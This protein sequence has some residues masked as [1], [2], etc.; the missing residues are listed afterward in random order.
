MVYDD[1]VDS[2]EVACA[3]M[4]RAPALHAVLPFVND[5]VAPELRTCLG[6]VRASVRVGAPVFLALIA[7]AGL[8]GAW[9][10]GIRDVVS[11]APVAAAACSALAAML[12]AAMAR[13]LGSRE[14]RG[15]G[16]Q[17]VVHGMVAVVAVATLIASLLGWIAAPSWVIVAGMTLAWFSGI[18][19]GIRELAASAIRLGSSPDV[20]ARLER[21]ARS[22]A[23]VWLV[24]LAAVGMAAAVSV[25]GSWYGTA[26]PALALARLVALALSGYACIGL[27][28]WAIVFEVALVV[29]RLR[30]DS[31][32][33]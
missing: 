19:V 1:S 10:F 23:S 26:R 16:R 7:I 30:K 4:P 33:P 17:A 31:T 12:F 21:R 28:C 27:A 5:A 29:E 20:V 8:P 22:G 3:T 25:I 14:P 18:L 11:P 9:S 6:W 32:G 24:G 13:T 15:A 2:A